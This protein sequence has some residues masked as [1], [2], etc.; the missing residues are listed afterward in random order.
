MLLQIAQV[1][2]QM[3]RANKQRIPVATN[4]TTT[5]FYRALGLSGSHS[6]WGFATHSNCASR[7]D[8]RRVVRINQSLWG[9][10]GNN[11]QY[12]DGGECTL[13]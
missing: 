10:E 11:C 7:P 12:S 6:L 2:F 1:L 3:Y 4:K 8:T 9:D 13:R 5:T